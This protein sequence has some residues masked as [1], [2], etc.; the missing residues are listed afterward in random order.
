MKETQHQGA[1]VRLLFVTHEPWPTFRPDVAALFGKYLPRFG[2]F[3]D[4]VAEQA[5]GDSGSQPWPAGRALLRHDRGG[6]A[7][8][9]VGKLLHNLR[10]LWACSRDDYDA[11][12]VRDLPVSALA[13]LIAARW[14]GLRFFYWMSFPIPESDIQRA[15]SR[16]PRAGLKYWFPLLQGRLGKWLLY[17]LVL[18]R[19]DHIFVQSER[20]KEDVAALGIPPQRM[21][22]VPMAVDLEAAQAER[23]VP[24]DDPRLTGKRVLAYLGTLDPAR[25]IDLLLDMM[26]KIHEV[27]DDVL[28]LL[29]G[30]TE[31]AAHRAWLEHRVEEL[32]LQHSILFTGWLKTADAWRYVRAAEIGVSPIPRDPL[33]DAGSP[34]KALEYLA[35]GICVVGNENPDQQRVII[36]SGAGQCVPL[37]AED[38]AKTILE[39][40]AD[41]ERCQ[42]LSAAGPGYIQRQ[43]NYQTLASRLAASYRALLGNTAKLSAQE[44]QTIGERNAP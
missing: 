8:H 23:I 19:A 10:T 27:Q 39:L 43:R 40:F 5:P 44:K 41:P 11:I 22:P 37:R 33:L 13:G 20:M 30:D 21:T 1:G 34:T 31:D 6:R 42:A 36:E 24:A 3:S 28:L 35:L 12:Q 38:F 7:M 17:K 16:G 18:P 32:G 4:L 2:I 26:V 9:H 14:K 15:Q 25:R 29:V